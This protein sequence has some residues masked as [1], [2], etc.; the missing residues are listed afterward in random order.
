VRQLLLA[1]FV[2]VLSPGPALLAADDPHAIIERAVKA[3]GG[4]ERI[5]Q[6]KAL[7]RRS[8]GSYPREGA[9]FTAETFSQDPGRLKII[10]RSSDPDAPSVRI[11]VLEGEKGWT[12]WNGFVQDIDEQMQARFRRARHADKVAGLT[13]LLRDKEKRYTLTALGAS[14]VKGKP[15]VGVKVSSPGQPDMS[16]FFDTASG[17][18]VKTAQRVTEPRVDNDSLQEWYYT[19]YKEIDPAGPD[20]ALL[21]AAKLDVSGPAL[22]ALLKQ[23][24]PGPESGAH[25]AELIKQLSAPAF[26]TRS[27]ATEELKKLGPQA[28]NQLREALKSTDREVVRRAEQCLNHYARH[29]ET[30]LVPAAVRLIA[31]RRP[32]GA[33]P[34]L[35]AYLPWAADEKTADEVVAAL[36]AVRGRDGKDD[37]ALVAAC[38][39]GNPAVRKAAAAALGRDG[40]AFLRRPGRRVVVPGLRFASRVELYRN[41]KREMELEV[42]DLQLF[43]RLDDSIFARPAAER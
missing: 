15:A 10:H 37:P 14:Q 18:L 16:L 11:L 27:K 24:T 43:N 5:Q 39:D 22:L 3:L 2:L 6:V 33:L 8:R 12:S 29:R 40:G 25:I 35:L 42:Q 32:P 20:E 30:P 19:N 41:G 13:A 9:V 31:L 1:L 34:V 4:L 28:A 21:K 17:L 23:R 7:Y 36:V 26:R 38:K